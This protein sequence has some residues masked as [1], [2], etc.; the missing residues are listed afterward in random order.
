MHRYNREEGACVVEIPDEE[1]AAETEGSGD[2]KEEKAECGFCLFMRAGPCGDEFRAWEACLEKCKEE[3][4]FAHQRP[5]PLR[6]ACVLFVAFAP[7]SSGDR[8]SPFL[9][10]LLRIPFSDTDFIEH[11][12]PQTIKLKNCVDQHPEY[13][14]VLNES[15]DDKKETE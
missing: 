6:I 7:R 12:G 8:C 4:P 9:P 14:E 10:R 3:G 15:Q 13:Y 5:Q 11:C 1:G 2:G